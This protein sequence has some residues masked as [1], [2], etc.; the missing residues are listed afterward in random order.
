MFDDY[1]PAMK[2]SAALLSGSILQSTT[3]I[4]PKIAW[5]NVVTNATTNCYFLYSTP[6]FDT[7]GQ[8]LPQHFY[9]TSKP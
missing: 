6:M 1:P 7:N 3:N 4:T 5:D 2:I 9:R 8:S